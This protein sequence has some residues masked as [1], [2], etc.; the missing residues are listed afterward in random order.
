MTKDLVYMM[1]NMRGERE[2]Q[3]NLLIHSE[4]RWR[5]ITGAH[6]RAQ[7][8]DVTDPAHRKQQLEDGEV[9][10]KHRAAADE[11]E[12]PKKSIDATRQATKIPDML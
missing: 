7:R 4:L 5:A 8:R 1:N 12:N 6:H 11:K 3:G 10:R 9:T 2:M